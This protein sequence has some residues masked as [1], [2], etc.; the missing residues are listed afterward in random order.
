VDG[1]DIG[2][3]HRAEV[4]VGSV[5]QPPG[6]VSGQIEPSDV[7]DAGKDVRQQ[8]LGSVGQLEEMG[9]HLRASQQSHQCVAGFGSLL[10]VFPIRGEP[11][12]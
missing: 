3:T 1:Q 10:R 7:R 9:R 6:L 8:M 12:L 11:D 4:L 5:Q 2:H